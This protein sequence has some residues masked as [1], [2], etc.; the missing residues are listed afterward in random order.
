MIFMTDPKRVPDPVTAAQRLPEGTAIIY[1]H[2][3]KE[4]RYEEAEALRQVTFA[5]RQQ[6]LI[7][8]DPG[9]A[10]IVGADGV[11]FR[12]DAALVLPSLWRKRCPD[13]IITMAGLK[14][15]QHYTGNLMASNGIFISSI[16]SSL[17]PSAGHP[18][19]I[20]TL[21]EICAKLP[22][23]VIALGGINV[24]TA[25]ELIGTGAAGL[26]GIEGLLP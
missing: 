7:G 4:E 25:P 24:K 17:S 3:G 6:L 8:H 2:F 16:F 11:H 10:I 9:L 18:I 26:A 14:G 21:T 1:R 5:R 12:R 13:W 19:G 15:S 23:P 20:E 22:V